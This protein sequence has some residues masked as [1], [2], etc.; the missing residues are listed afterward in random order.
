MTVMLLDPIGARTACAILAVD[1]ST[2][3]R[4]VH[5]G[6]LAATRVDGCWVLERHAVDA[7]AAERAQ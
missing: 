2:L 5:S 3:L 7:L 6:S 4:W 1:R